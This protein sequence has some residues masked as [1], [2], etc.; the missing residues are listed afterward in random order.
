EQTAYTAQ[1]DVVI[2]S[3]T[4]EGVFQWTKRLGGSNYSGGN[5]VTTDSNSNVIVTGYVKG[6]ADLNGNA[7]ST[8]GG[9]ETASSTYQNN[10]IF[11]SS[12]TS[13]GTYK[14]SKRLGGA[15]ADFGLSVTTDNSN[16]VIVTGYVVG[17]ADLNGDGDSNDGGTEATSSYAGTSEPFISSFTTE[18]VY[19]WSQRLGAASGAGR[20]IITDSSDNIIVTGEVSGDAD[21]NGD[22][23]T[24][25]SGAE[26]ALGYGGNDIFVTSFSSAGT[27]KW[28]QRLG[29]SDASGWPA[30]DIG[31]SVARDANDTI[32]NRASVW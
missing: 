11:L 7:T 9:A 13:T 6:D 1:G 21:L 18:G 16:N 12:F 19:Q 10:D 29:G 5:S 15:G 8:D 23:S 3:F 25:S 32:Y 2:S 27:F 20:S 24:D 28:S 26:S 14:W 31:Y 30:E 22:G 17:A 4:T